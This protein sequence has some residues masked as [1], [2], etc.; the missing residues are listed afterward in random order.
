MKNSFLITPDENIVPL[1]Q[2]LFGN[3]INFD[4]NRQ[5]KEF[6]DAVQKMM[7]A[8]AEKMESDEILCEAAAKIANYVDNVNSENR[9]MQQLFGFIRN[10]DKKTTFEEWLEFIKERMD[11]QARG[12]FLADLKIKSAI[13]Y[14]RAKNFARQF[15]KKT[16]TFDSIRQNLEI[17]TLSEAFPF[18]KI[19]KNSEGEQDKT[20]VDTSEILFTDFVRNVNLKD[21]II[22]LNGETLAVSFSVNNEVKAWLNKYFKK[23]LGKCKEFLDN[24]NDEKNDSSAKTAHELEQQ[25][26]EALENVSEKPELNLFGSVGAI[27][28]DDE[29]NGDLIY[30]LFDNSMNEVQFFGLNYC[31]RWRYVRG[32]QNLFRCVGTKEFFVPKLAPYIFSEKNKNSGREYYKSM[33]REVVRHMNKSKQ[34]EE[35]KLSS[36]SKNPWQDIYKYMGLPAAGGKYEIILS[37]KKGTEEYTVLNIPLKNAETCEF[38]I[39]QNAPTNIV[40]RI[41]I[42][43][44]VDFSLR[45]GVKEMFNFACGKS[46]EYSFSQVI[47]NEIN[48]DIKNEIA[49]GKPALYGF[50]LDVLNNS[51]PTSDGSIRDVFQ[52]YTNCFC[53]NEGIPGLQR[54][55]VAPSDQEVVMLGNTCDKIVNLPENGDYLNKYEDNVEYRVTLNFKEIVGL[56]WRMM[57]EAGE[58]A[59]VPESKIKFIY[60]DNDTDIIGLKIFDMEFQFKLSGVK[61]PFELDKKKLSEALAK[62]LSDNAEKYAEEKNAKPKLDFIM[63]F[64]GEKRYYSRKCIYV[65][66]KSD[67]LLNLY[68]FALLGKD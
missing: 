34:G 9:D 41:E 46:K 27:G 26:Y 17:M 58:K 43:D 45:Q 16:V 8:T 31:W 1:S 29:K 30:Y 53:V 36:Y 63:S 10:D 22:T 13:F 62:C 11:E 2:V 37:V 64:V 42:S 23:Y 66:D 60:A 18:V 39:V 50:C 52:R 33:I 51:A 12:F 32:T 21:G 61:Q 67:S 55:I 28:L 24:K 19:A 6:F 7:N 49:P 38:A 5:H 48:N 15:G 40:K 57:V 25:F 68:R 20:T 59:S 14:L 47:N 54:N 35:N 3:E 4:K 65:N 44:K 56:F